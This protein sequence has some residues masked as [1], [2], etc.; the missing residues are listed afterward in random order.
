MGQLN[1]QRC[2]TLGQQI[3]QKQQFKPHYII[4]VKKLK[5]KDRIPND[6]FDKIDKKLREEA[7]D[8]QPVK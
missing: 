8:N 2:L 1:Q 5:K 3:V 6:F 4:E 7:E